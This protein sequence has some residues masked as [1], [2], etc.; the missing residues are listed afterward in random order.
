[1]LVKQGCSCDSKEMNVLS[2]GHP[3]LLRCANTRGLMNDSL[4]LKKWRENLIKIVHGIIRSKPLNCDINLGLDHV[5]KVGKNRANIIFIFHKIYPRSTSTIINTFGT[6]NIRNRRWSPNITTN[7]RKRN[8]HFCINY[9]LDK[10][11]A[12][13]LQT[14]NHYNENFQQWTL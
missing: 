1:M 11:H 14:H 10:K 2:F 12:Y 7:E 13:V 8:K 4:S 6:I 9:L 5:V 3:I